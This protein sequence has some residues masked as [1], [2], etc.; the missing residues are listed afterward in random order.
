MSSYS[1]DK[2]IKLQERVIETL[3]EDLG[4]SYIG[5]LKE[6]ENRNIRLD[7][8]KSS[9]ARRGYSEYYISKALRE[10]DNIASNQR[11]GLYAN[12]KEFYSLLRYGVKV[13]EKNSN[14]RITID[15]INWGDVDNNDFAVAEEVTTL[16]KDQKT[17]KRPDVV[18]YIN[19][20]ALAIF[21]LK[22]SSV[23]IG[24]GIRQNLTNQQEENISTFFNTIQ[25]VFAGNEA[26][27]LKYGTTATPEN[28]F[29]DWKEDNNATD[30]LSNDIRELRK[31]I[32]NKLSKDI[33]SLCQKERFL[34]IIK[35]YV[36]FDA[37]IKKLARHN[38]YFA[39]MAA[40]DYIKRGEGGIIWNTQGSGKS[41]IMVWL[42][43]WVIENI[44]QSRVV[45]ITDRT[46]L[47]EQI[48]SL[49]LN[50]GEKV[51]RAKSGIDLRN[52]LNTNESSIICSLIHKY[53]RN[54][55]KD[56]DILQY[57]SELKNS[58]GTDYEAK[59]NIVAFIDE[60]HRT[61][62]GKLHEAVR[63]LMPEA[64][65]IGFTG[66]PLLSKDKKTSR[67]I[68]GDYIHTY[69]FDEG[70]K[71][72]VV[73]DLRYEAR[74]IDQELTNQ[75]KVDTWFDR[76]S[77][78]LTE[79]AKEDL[80]R[81]WTSLNKL[82]SSKDRLEK[83]AA[84]IIYDMDTR[85]RLA[86]DRGT[87]MLVADSIYSACRYWDIFQS[88]G[89]RNCAVVSSFEPSQA[90][91]RV[92]TINLNEQS[93]DEYKK[94]IYERMLD[95]KSTE[96][97]EKEVK[98][99]FKEEPSNMK[100]LIVVD[101][102]L[103]GFDAPS[104]TYLY[105]DK[106]MRDH[107][108]FQAI[109]RVNR[110][111]GEDKDFGYIVD[112]KDLFKNLQ[113]SIND[114]TNGAFEDY[115]SKDVEGLLKNRY[116]EA[117]AQMEQSRLN[118]IEFF[119]NIPNSNDDS[120]VINYFCHDVDEETSTARRGYLYSLVSSYTRSFADC[121]D[122]LESH[123]SYNKSD[124]KKI[125][126]E[127]SNFNNIKDMIKQASNDYIDLKPYEIGMRF[128]L[129]SYVKA[130]NS[131]I[132][133]KLD[134]MSLIELLMDGSSNESKEEIIEDFPG[135]EEAVAETIENNISHEIVVKKSKNEVY[136][137]KLSKMLEDIIELR[138]LSAISYEEYLKEII[139][140]AK[141]VY[142]PETNNTY[143]EDIR[144]NEAKMALFD[145]I[146]LDNPTLAIEMDSAIKSAIEPNW[147]EN[148]IKQNR[149]KR[150]I[151]N[152]FIDFGFEE[153]MADSLVEKIMDI[154]KLQDEYTQL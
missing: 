154:V 59:G 57:I 129:D 19:G 126:R 144:G 103:T 106:S 69:K 80:K 55:G 1:V 138:R 46:E 38:Q 89:F 83:I 112:Y 28:F 133:S 78:G 31:N 118:L 95:G 93:E 74:D 9:L 87:A 113:N 29:L 131:R 24:E 36:I 92:S 51:K 88:K 153:N 62:S 67:E 54:A 76:K 100:L 146:G 137:N 149:I 25:F 148:I 73:L 127:I 45:I 94:E 4:Y 10:V 104:A 14:K 97:F 33:I 115:D 130:E 16:R 107:D 125:R 101:K 50:V 132:I 117:V 116:D 124:I 3:S 143:P 48:E 136:Y 81:S 49:F 86:E 53:G 47:D 142:N 110:P 128:I 41:L 30:R 84:D 66:T 152:K 13:K 26:K 109:C 85:Q 37:G 43:K 105:I 71:D 70:V 123:Y 5:N 68:F 17:H 52:A 58:L 141:K 32:D 145:Y 64:T 18:I 34:S 139:D 20:I 135:D 96:Q 56:S 27:G 42:A 21:E 6:K 91:V 79:S 23:S 11:D 44:S 121:V 108:L 15:L 12:N 102:L 98:Q 82:Y 147:R 119:D 2:E 151:F 7:D 72:G 134:D 60:C 99:K 122:R 35:D 75:E 90:S 40:H 65:L 39:N 63:V 77:Q 120:S 22:R 61:N 114:Y 8:L 111:D 140:L 150:S